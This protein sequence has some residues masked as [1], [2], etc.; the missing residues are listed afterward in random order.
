MPRPKPKRGS[1]AWSARPHVLSEST[2]K[3]LIGLLGLDIISEVDS[4]RAGQALHKVEHWLGFYP[5]A[6]QAKAGVPG[7]A[8]Y[9]AVLVPIR[10]RVSGLANRLRG[11]HPWMRRELEVRGANVDS[12]EEDLT[13]LGDVISSTIADIGSG[14][15]RGKPKDAALRV[16]IGKLRRVFIRYHAGNYVVGVLSRRTTGAINPLS[17]PEAEEVDFVE[18]ALQDAGIPCP[19]NIRRL[20]DEPDAALPY[21]V[22]RQKV[23][24]K[25]ARKVRL[26]RQAQSRKT[27]KRRRKP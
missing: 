24:E 27:T 6:V 1:P 16:L 13:K 22:L 5:G 25:I 9:R 10:T 11:L 15:G 7:P 2:K 20:F 17:K 12:L 21:V 23:M 19:Q 3:V 8:D 4:K 18:T 26:D 14:G